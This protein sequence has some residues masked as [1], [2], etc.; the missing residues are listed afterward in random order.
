MRK[1]NFSFSH[2]L[3]QNFI[4]NPDVVSNIIKFCNVNKKTSVLEIG[5][6]V[7]SL[8]RELALHAKR[9]VSIEIDKKLIP[10]LNE[11]LKDFKNVSLINEDFLKLNLNKLWNDYFKDEKVV[12][13]ANLPYYITSAIIVKILN[14][15]IPFDSM[16]IMLQK[17]VASRICAPVGTRMTGVISLVVNYYCTPEF[18]FDVDKNNFLPIPKV[19]SAVIKLNKLKV[20]P[21]N[22]IDK[23][24]FF[25]IIKSSFAKRRKTILNSI[26]A[27]NGLSKEEVK[28]IL[29]EMNLAN[30]RAENLSLEQFTELSNQVAKVI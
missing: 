10:L 7:G 24:I 4:I 3:G 22:V 21:V 16:T 14:S 25:K 17:E 9:V 2:Q 6:G 11:T 20:P 12:I 27:F 30:L 26:G 13:C 5:T 1:Y 28:K 18:L 15:E 8:T 23:N 19:D 29:D